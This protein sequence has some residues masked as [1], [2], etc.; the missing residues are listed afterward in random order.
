[1]GPLSWLL[2]GAL[3]GWLASMVTGSKDQRGCLGNI[4]LG[5]VGAFVGGVLMK[6]LTGE[7]FNFGFSL[8]S[9]VV[10]IIGSLIVLALVGAAKRKR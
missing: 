3:A 4:V 9:F 5:I 8:N 10:A 6:F 1:M 2:F 7:E